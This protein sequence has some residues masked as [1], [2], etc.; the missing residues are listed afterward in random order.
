MKK[1]KFSVVDIIIA[2]VLIIWGFAIFYPFYNSV[3]ISFMTEA[4]LLKNPY[5]FYVK[6]VSFA[7]YKYIFSDGLIFTGYRNSLIM[8]LIGV[9]LSLIVTAALAYALSRKSFLLSKT[10]NNLVV[11]TM[12]FGGGLVPTYLLIKNLGLMNSLW[13]VILP[14]VVT[15]Y[16]MILIK[17]YFYS[18]PDSL[19]ESAKLDGAND[20]IIFSKI[21]FPLAKPILASVG[22]F[23]TVSKWND[24][25]HPM[26]YLKSSMKWPVQ[27]VLKEIITDTATEVE[28]GGIMGEVFSN[29][30]KMATIV[31][32]VTPIML[33]YPFLQKY[34]MKG[35][36]VGA[37][38]G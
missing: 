18:T 14:T 31:A 38:K 11:F 22:L 36:M 26:L 34:F 3:L 9:P 24:W 25:Y 4:E 21:Y 13:S 27:L 15:T 1:K 30:I 17:S 33:V 12:Y 2:S 6:D 29:N 7:A 19:E 37:V 5:A 28:E 8:V 10:I 32:T 23:Y 35:I 16:N 20:V